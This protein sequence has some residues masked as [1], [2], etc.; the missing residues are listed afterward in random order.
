[1]ISLKKKIIITIVV[2]L[3]TLTVGGTIYAVVQSREHMEN[4]ENAKK[5]MEFE[6]QTLD[7]IL[8]QLESYNLDGGYLAKDLTAKKLDEVEKSLNM[9]KESYIDFHIKKDDLNDERKVI[10]Q[11]KKSIQQNIDGLKDKVQLQQKVNKLFGKDVLVGSEV[12]E[13]AVAD[14]LPKELVQK[15]KDEDI[16]KVK[17]DSKWKDTLVTSIDNAIS[18]LDQIELAQKKV[19]GV[20]KNGEVVNGVT[21]DVY[22]KVK[23]EVDKVKNENSKSGLTDTLTK[24]LKVVEADELKVKEEAEARAQAEKAEAQEVEKANSPSN[25]GT[26]MANNSSSNVTSNSNSSNTPSA[27]SSS[28]S[29]SAS[30]H[31]SSQSSDSSRSK[32]NSS[33][34]SGASNS[35]AGT[36]VKKTGE[37]CINPN[38]SFDSSKK[39]SEG[40]PCDGGN[41]WEGGTFDPPEA[42]CKDFGC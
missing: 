42:Y 41:W 32:G 11:D 38:K 22:N 35:N 26:S 15:L 33:S 24:V 16:I 31:S 7:S 8:T 29:T 10:K 21:R 30:K 13:Q 34:S 2:L 19:A 14:N 20:F 39:S 4:M 27:S 17:E 9:V 18:Q 5:Q 25:G 12:S 23:T 37:G 6:Q 28:N 36:N 3:G 40:G 1:M